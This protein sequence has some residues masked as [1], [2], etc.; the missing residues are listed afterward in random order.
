M[1][2]F[3]SWEDL[4]DAVVAKVTLISREEAKQRCADVH[5]LVQGS[6]AWARNVLLSSISHCQT[7]QNIEPVCAPAIPSCQV[8]WCTVPL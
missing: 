5:R 2:A 3:L 6:I 1:E 8:V 7:P 4:V